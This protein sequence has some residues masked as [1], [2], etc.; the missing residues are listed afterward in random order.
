MLAKFVEKKFDIFRVEKSR[1]NLSKFVDCR[2]KF[3]KCR[4]LLRIL[5]KKFDII[6]PSSST[7]V[8]KCRISFDS[9]RHISTLGRNLSNNLRP[10]STTASSAK[11]VEKIFD[12]FRAS[13]DIWRKLSNYLSTIFDTSRRPLL[14][15]FD[16]IRQKICRM[17]TNAVEICRLLST[18]VVAKNAVEKDRRNL[19]IR[20][21]KCRTPSKNVVEICRL[22]STNVEC[23][24]KKM[25]KFVEKCWRK[26]LSKNAVEK[27]R[28]LSKFVDCC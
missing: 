7:S 19:S 27:N 21:D 22:P 9:F 10:I 2:R 3:R 17:M 28:T 15:A 6:R 18:N 12:I 20:V 23:C 26:M 4:P 25:A 24:R 8:E 1:R 5:S 11:F 14:T 16:T 13:S